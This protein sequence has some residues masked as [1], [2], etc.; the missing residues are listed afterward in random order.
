MIIRNFPTISLWYVKF[1]AHSGGK[2]PEVNE[3]SSIDLL[4]SFLDLGNILR[5]ERCSIFHHS[6]QRFLN[7]S[8]GIGKISRLHLV[9]DESLEYRISESYFH[10]AHYINETS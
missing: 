2:L 4:V 7:Y 10:E 6:R 9:I 3:F 1:G 8:V 5:H